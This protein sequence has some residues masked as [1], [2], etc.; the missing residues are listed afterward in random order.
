MMMRIAGVVSV[1]LAASS[2]WAQKPALTT[3]PGNMGTSPSFYCGHLVANKDCTAS[4]DEVDSALA[5]CDHSFLAPGSA[6]LSQAHREY[7]ISACSE[8]LAYTNSAAYQQRKQKRDA[9][10]IEAAKHQ[11]EVI[12]GSLPK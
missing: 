3:L 10:A 8:L 6:V 12:A 7:T 9:E 1:L 5:I 4:D 11:V 2:S